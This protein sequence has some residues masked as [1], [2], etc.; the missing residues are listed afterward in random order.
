M[1]ASS[2]SSSAPNALGKIVLVGCSGIIGKATMHALNRI[3]GFNQYVVL[4][5]DPSGF[6]PAEHVCSGCHIAKGDL[7]NPD[8]LKSAFEGATAVFIITPS[9]ENRATLM[10]N[11]LDAA[12]AAGVPFVLV[13]SVSTA[14]SVRT[15]FGKQFAAIEATTKA[16]GLPYAIMRLP[17]F[18]DNLQCDFASVAAT[19]KICGA[20]DPMALHTTVCAHDAGEAAAEILLK[21]SSH[22]NMTY[23]IVGPT[24]RLCDA[25]TAFSEVLGRPVQYE[26]K[27]YDAIERALVDAGTLPEWQIKGMIELWHMIDDGTY[28]FKDTDYHKLTGKQPMSMHKWVEHHRHEIHGIVG[29]SSLPTGTGTATTSE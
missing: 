24:W 7:A 25:A 16:S 23:H 10:Q 19:G 17:L 2:S 6:H 4:T 21:P 27:P 15:I 11:G 14:P 26:R 22:M 28:N 12:K 20:I 8:K 29:H 1:A 13:L 5:R 3:A 9:V 18:T